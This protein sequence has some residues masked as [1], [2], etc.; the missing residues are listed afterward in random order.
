M[1][2]E[3]VGEAD[4]HSADGDS[5]EQAIDVMDSPEMGFHGQPAL[6]PAHLADLGEVPLTH[7]EARGRGGGGGGGG[8]GYSLGVD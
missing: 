1:L 2:L 8:G 4:Q 6:E 7:E 5:E 3:V